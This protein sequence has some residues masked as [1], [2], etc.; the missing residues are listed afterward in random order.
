MR[1]LI[2]GCILAAF[3]GGTIAVAQSPITATKPLTTPGLNQPLL[4]PPAT[5]PK[6]SPSHVG[7]G[8]GLGARTVPGIA[9]VTNPQAT[10]GGSDAEKIG[11][12]EQKVWLPQN[13]RMS[14]PDKPAKVDAAI[15]KQSTKS[16]QLG[17]ARDYAK[18]PSKENEG[19]RFRTWGPGYSPDKSSK[20][21]TKYGTWGSGYTPDKSSSEESKYGTYGARYTPDKSSNDKS[22]YG[23]WGPGYTPDTKTKPLGMGLGPKLSPPASDPA[24]SRSGVK[25]SAPG[26]AAQSG[27]MTIEEV[28]V[29]KEEYVGT[30]R[31]GS[32]K[33][34]GEDEAKDGAD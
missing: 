11:A 30:P 10:K 25:P 31:G 3:L 19:A 4:V 16:D 33:P 34:A 13:F 18:P 24:L 1:R 14:L 17:S 21:E 28:E 20:D 12:S 6:N 22:K 5:T 15:T 27:A 8:L 9:P 7:V 23:T 26:I 32:A 29:A 2:L